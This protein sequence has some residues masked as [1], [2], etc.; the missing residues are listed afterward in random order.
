[1]HISINGHIRKG[2][3]QPNIPKVIAAAA[4]TTTTIATTLAPEGGRSCSRRGGSRP[5]DG[6]GVGAGHLLATPP[7]S[8]STGVA[9]KQPTDVV[10]VQTY[11]LD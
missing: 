7:A 11:L 2:H 4:A 10:V 6:G 9:G 8:P 1:M 5:T 3:S